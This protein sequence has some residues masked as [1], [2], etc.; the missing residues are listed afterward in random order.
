[1]SESKII[2]LPKK[3]PLAERISEAKQIISE[4]TK[5][6]NIPFNE[7]IDAIQLKKCER[8]KKEYLYHYIIACG[9][10]NSWRQW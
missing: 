3:L 2:N 8:N 10:K 4:W 6:L 7:K 1:M 9:T 5:S